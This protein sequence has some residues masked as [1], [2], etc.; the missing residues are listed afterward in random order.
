M[1][2][3]I[4]KTVSIGFTD[5]NF[6][7]SVLNLLNTQNV[8]SVF[9]RTGDPA[10]D[11]WLASASGIQEAS[12]ATNPAQYAAI[13]QARYLGNNVTTGNGSFGSNYGAPRQ[14]HF[15]MKLEF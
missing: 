12:G 4:D 7:I 10:D 3:R 11:G 14:I 8:V 13:Y 5:V 9:A 1:D 2:L 15:G 6:Y